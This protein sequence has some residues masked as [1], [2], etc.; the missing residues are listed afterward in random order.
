MQTVREIEANKEKIEVF[1]RYLKEIGI[2]EI[3]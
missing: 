3:S 2:K 1:E